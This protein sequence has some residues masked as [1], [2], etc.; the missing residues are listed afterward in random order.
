MDRGYINFYSSENST[1][2]AFSHIPFCI[3]E[4]SKIVIAS[5][6][7]EDGFGIMAPNG[8]DQK[9]SIAPGGKYGLW[10]DFLPPIANTGLGISMVRFIQCHPLYDKIN[11][12]TVAVLKPQRRW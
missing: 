9:G 10:Y 6:R 3:V 4:N 7:V 2:A 5:G 1:G 12:N 11:C 8:A